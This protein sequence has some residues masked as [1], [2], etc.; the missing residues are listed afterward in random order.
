MTS[1][2]CDFYFALLAIITI[3]R[4]CSLCVRELSA[5]QMVVNRYFHNKFLLT[6]GER[7]R[8]LVRDLPVQRSLIAQ[9][10]SAY[11]VRLTA[12]IRANNISRARFIWTNFNGLVLHLHPANARSVIACITFPK[13]VRFLRRT[14]RWI[15]CIGA[16]NGASLIKCMRLPRQTAALC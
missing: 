11:I 3:I 13:C 4:F 16:A 10:G 9:I 8:T 2:I 15:C 12:I 5:G 6:E 7:W 1:F 14:Q